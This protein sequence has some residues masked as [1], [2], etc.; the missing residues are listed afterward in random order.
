MPRLY[1]NTPPRLDSV[2]AAYQSPLYFVTFR[3]WH[4]C[5][6]LAC[7]S[8]KAA[9]EDY[10]R[11]NMEQG[12]ALGRYVIMPDHIHLFCRL[13]G[14]DQLGQF[15]R[16]MKQRLG[17]ALKAE[18]HSAPYWQ[19][20]FFDHLLRKA[21]SYSEKWAYVRQNPVRKGLVASADEWPYQG[22]VVS[23]RY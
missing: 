6:F 5:S 9:I 20:G 17:R 3:A 11:A 1:K 14:E 4:E 16:L 22:E 18:G 2:F 23:I 15:I 21:D 10:G 12:R 19:P 8:V 13:S 7:D